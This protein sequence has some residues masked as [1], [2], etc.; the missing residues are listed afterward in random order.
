MA[1]GR[2]PSICVFR[3]TMSCAD[4]ANL[5]PWPHCTLYGKGKIMTRGPQG[6]FATPTHMKA[7][8]FDKYG[9]IDVLQVTGVP[10]PEPAHGEVLVKVKAASINPGAI[11]RRD[12]GRS[13]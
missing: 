12:F 9:G 8:R 1:A 10:V 13:A 2:T 5:A 6:K 7:V 3:C 4:R 11:P